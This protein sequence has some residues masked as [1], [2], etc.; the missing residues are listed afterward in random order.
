VAHVTFTNL[1]CSYANETCGEFNI[2]HIKAVNRTHKYISINGKAN[3]IL[4]NITGNLKVMRYDYGYKPFFIDISVDICKF[5]K[6]PQNVIL[7]TFFNTFRKSSN[8]NHTCPFDHAIIVDKL[9]TGNLEDGFGR[10]LPIPNGDYVI[11]L[12]FYTNKVELAKVAVYIRKS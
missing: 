6:N 9:W 2:C 11:F 12:T 5:L 8:M 3:V 1:K 7:I 10:Y 4:D